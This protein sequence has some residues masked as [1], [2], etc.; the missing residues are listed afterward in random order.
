MNIGFYCG[1]LFPPAMRGGIQSYVLR[2]AREIGASGAHR[3]HLLTDREPDAS[4]TPMSGV[5]LHTVRPR[6][7]P[8]LGR[9]LRGLGE[10]RDIAKALRRL[11]REHALDVVEFPNW[12]APG[13]VYT[14]TNDVP[15][16]TR[17]STCFAETMK[18]DALRIGWG[19][20]F[21]RWSERTAARR[22]AALVTHTQAHR[23]Y[24]AR[25]IGLPESAIAVIPLGIEVPDQPLPPVARE[26]NA[27]IEVLYVGRLEHRKGT[28][29]LLHALPSVNA[30]APAFRLTLI[31]R[32]RRHAP[33]RRTFREYAEQELPPAVRERLVF[34][35]VVSGEE[36]DAAY[37]GCD[38]FVAPSLYESFGL[39]YIEAM[40][41]ARPA[42]GC[43]AGG[44]PEVVRHGHT[45]LLVEPSRPEALAGAMAS[46][47][48]NA[49]LRRTMGL[50]AHAWTR[51][52]FSIQVMAE[53][54][55]AF[56]ENVRTRHR[57]AA[58]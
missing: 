6:W 41:Y 44:I 36:L 8:V 2:L 18:I 24:M 13:L 19:E 23:A 9:W 16:V 31:G 38:L 22:S 42:I 52:N 25:E 34:R 39:T 17:L 28:L 46:L 32:D 55:I 11:V 43:R 30:Q 49:D 48:T 50:N 35:D 14:R 26:P 53:R 54:M 4:W 5:T 20:R 57:K 3:V 27:P 15:S 37:R 10:S 12:E 29:D 40:R 21:I 45:G 1:A 7:I 33:G 56:Y 51:E 58:P 47:L